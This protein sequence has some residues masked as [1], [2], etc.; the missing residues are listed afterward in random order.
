[1]QEITHLEGRKRGNQDQEAKN[2]TAKNEQALQ[3]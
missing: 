1:V 3:I 2:S